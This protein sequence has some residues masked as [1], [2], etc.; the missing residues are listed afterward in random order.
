MF[1]PLDKKDRKAVSMKDIARCENCNNDISYTTNSIN[2]RIA[3]VNERI[4]SCGGVV[5]DMMI[6]PQLENDLRFCGLGCLKSWVN[7]E[8]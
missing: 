6:Y 7:K 4:P 5:T 1:V 3:L 8:K 2:W